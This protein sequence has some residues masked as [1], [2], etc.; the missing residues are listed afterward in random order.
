MKSFVATGLVLAVLG[1]APLQCRHDPDPSVRT[2]DTAGDAL[3]ALAQDFRSKGN[4]DAARQTLAFLVERY[5]SNRH[6]PVARAELEAA[7]V[8]LLGPTRDAGPGG[9]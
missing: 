1:G 9:G 5:P 8:K 2:E 6:A 3:W 7:G 4:E